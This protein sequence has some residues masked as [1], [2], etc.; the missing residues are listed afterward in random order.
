MSTL[1][2]Q[3]RLWSCSSLDEAL[4]VMGATGEM[5]SDPEE[6]KVVVK[7]IELLNLFFDLFKIIYMLCIHWIIGSVILPK[8]R[9]L[10]V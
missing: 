2:L 4:A 9:L 6:L 3:S 1:N 7:E 8:K 5:P 10:N